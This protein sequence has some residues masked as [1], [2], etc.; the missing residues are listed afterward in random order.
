MQEAARDAKQAKLASGSKD[1]YQYTLTDL[2][3]SVGSASSSGAAPSASTPASEKKGLKREL[4]DPLLASSDEDQVCTVANF[5]NL[6]RAPPSL[7]FSD[8]NG[9]YD[10]TSH[11]PL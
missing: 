11:R 10:S 8:P 3:V 4:S 9:P 5:P 7:A 1:T 6:D 2:G